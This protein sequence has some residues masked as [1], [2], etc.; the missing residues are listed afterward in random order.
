MAFFSLDMHVSMHVIF[1][2][3]VLLYSTHG[4][5]QKGNTIKGKIAMSII[6]WKINSENSFLKA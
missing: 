1:I 6:K 3:F 2:T 5:T 4:K